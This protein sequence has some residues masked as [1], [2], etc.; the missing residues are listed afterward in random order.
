MLEEKATVSTVNLSPLEWNIKDLLSHSAPVE[1][2]IATGATSTNMHL[3]QVELCAPRGN[4]RLSQTR[5]G[6]DKS[7]RARGQE[8]GGGG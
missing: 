2:N 7:K 8:R 4:V 5:T 6:K 3:F 1:T